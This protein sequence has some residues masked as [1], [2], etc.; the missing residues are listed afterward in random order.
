LR[1]LPAQRATF[2]IGAGGGISTVIKSE[3]NM[4][5]HVD[6]PFAALQA[7]NDRK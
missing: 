1:W 6:K 4:N 2:V 3:V 7:V 5:I